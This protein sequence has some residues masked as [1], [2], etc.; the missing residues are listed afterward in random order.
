[1]VKRTVKFDYESFYS[2]GK[3]DEEFVM[4]C[5]K[6]TFGGT[7]ERATR[8][9]DMFDH[10][11]FWWD[12]PKKGRIGIDVKGIKKKK[13]SDKEGDDSINW[14]EI[15]NVNG[16]PGWIYGKATYIAFRTNNGILFVKNSKLIEYIEEKV[17]FKVL[18]YRN[19]KAFYIPYQR[20]GRKDVVVMIPTSDL[21]E[22][23]DFSIDIENN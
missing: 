12:S 9:E 1:M 3:M 4:E 15:K 5:T 17:D 7:C 19:P 16:N 10:V 23:A 6:N 18:V 20:F 14:I 22:L 8:D 21:A 11:D 13:R 2:K